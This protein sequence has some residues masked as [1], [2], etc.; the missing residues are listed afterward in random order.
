MLANTS[1]MLLGLAVAGQLDQPS[2]SHQKPDHRFLIVAP[3]DWSRLLRPF[4]QHKR[5]QLPTK[6]ATLEAVLARNDGVDDA[7]KVKRFLYRQYVDH[8]VRYV[9]LVGDVDV[10]PVRYMVLDRKTESA[11]NFAFYP[12]DLYYSDLLKRDGKSFEDWNGQSK[13]LHK[14]YFGEVRG[15]HFKS[16]PINFD[17]IEY[18]PELAVGRWPVSNRKQLTTI[19]AK[20]IRYETKLHQRT[21]PSLRVALYSVGGWVDS[22]P[23]MDFAAEKLA[24]RSTIAKRYYSDSKRPSQ[25]SP[26][27]EQLIG[28]FSRGV[29]LV[30]HAGHGTRTSWEQCLRQEDLAKLDNA[31]RLP[32]VVSVG[33]ST[34]HFAPE[35]PYTPYTDFLGKHHTGTNKGEIF[36]APPPAPAPYQKR[37]NS[38]GLGEQL[39][40]DSE[41]GAVAYIGCC[42]GSQ[43]CG[44]DFIRG[45]SEAIAA[46]KQP[47]LGDAWMKTIEFYHLSQRLDSLK[48][49]SDWY[50]PSIYF[51]GMKF[52]VFGDPTLLMSPAP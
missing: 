7:E 15:E 14:R 41:N 13:G 48:P 9:L 34:A 17:N 49:T 8:A 24:N 43:P 38:G 30:F 31:D 3:S 4:V 18:L 37:F 5:R 26:T 19:V 35:P 28:D 29:D 2:E 32:I 45:F 47:R 16:D 21:V 6:L 11:F 40:R 51:Q 10:L 42:T 33:C 12:S 25:Q 44:L 50:P 39:I 1:I 52:M 36:T 22:R 20:T 27:R 23:T 46:S